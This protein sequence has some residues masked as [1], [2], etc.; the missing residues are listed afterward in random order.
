MFFIG[1]FGI[2]QKEKEISSFNAVC[3]DCARISKAT[4]FMRYSYFHIFFIPT[5]RWRRQYFV[6]LRCCGSLLEV[7]DDYAQEL[8][9]AGTIDFSR[10]KK[11]GGAK[12]PD[13]FYAACRAC[14][15]NFDKSFPFC[16]YCGEKQ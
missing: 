10:L 12:S 13:D 1:I 14:G 7:P 2:G 16:P 4:F 5:F 15:K 3:P 6:K 9:T 11:A 8:K